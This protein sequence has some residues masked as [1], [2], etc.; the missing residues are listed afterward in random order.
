MT[1]S[2][3]YQYRGKDI[4]VVCSD[5]QRVNGFCGIVTSALD[6]EPDP[7]SITLETPAGLVEIT[8]PEIKEIQILS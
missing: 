8:E 5:G 2:E 7:A 1:E 6:N 3:L 4:S